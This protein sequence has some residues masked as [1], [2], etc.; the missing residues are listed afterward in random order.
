MKTIKINDTGA[1]V[2]ILQHALGI[3][4]D[5][6]FGPV[7]DRS[8]KS[9]QRDK[10]LEPDGIAGPRTWETLL[11]YNLKRSARS[12]NEV[13]IHCTATHEG[14]NYTVEQI[15]AYHRKEKGWKDIGYHYVIYLDGSVHTGRDVDQQGAHCKYHNQHSVGVV[16][17]GGTDAQGKSKDTRTPQQRRSMDDLVY[18]LR[19]LYPRA[20][21]HGHREYANKDCPCFDVRR[22]YGNN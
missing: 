8:L 16:Y 3:E 9:Y 14:E 19:R 20:G 2:A 21:F 4:D 17:V 1:E 12:I 10:G 13:I 22:E 18:N 11:G 6:V 5:G 7:T 15:R